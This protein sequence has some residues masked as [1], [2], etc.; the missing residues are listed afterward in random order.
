MCRIFYRGGVDDVGLITG[1]TD[2]EDLEAF[3]LS[4]TG[5]KQG[6]SAPE[7]PPPDTRL[8]CQV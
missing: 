2:R 1:Y 5:G 8:I 3:I 7:L 6:G 4:K